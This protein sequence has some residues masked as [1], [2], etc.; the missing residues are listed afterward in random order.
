[1][2]HSIFTNNLNKQKVNA[3]R[4]LEEQGA[5]LHS[6]A[7]IIVLIRLLLVVVVVVIL[8]CVYIYIYKDR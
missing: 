3:Q 1:M 2:E 7:F 6:E 8:L 4:E 5:K